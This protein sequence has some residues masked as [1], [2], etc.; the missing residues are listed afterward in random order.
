MFLKKILRWL[1]GPEW[2]VDLPE[3]REMKGYLTIS[4]LDDYPVFI[5]PN[6]VQLDS[7][8]LWVH[9]FVEA[10][11][12]NIMP[13]HRWRSFGVFRFSVIHALTSF[14]CESFIGSRQVS[15]D[16]FWKMVSPFS[17]SRAVYTLRE[18]FGFRG[19]RFYDLYSDERVSK[20]GLSR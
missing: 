5:V 10:C 16:E 18:R 3:I 6:Y 2:S 13:Y 7:P 9:E 20:D 1:K 15:P 4:I 12:W 19:N 17:N 8:E 11:L 14:S